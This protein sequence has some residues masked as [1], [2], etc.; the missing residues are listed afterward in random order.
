MGFNCARNI[1]SV[2]GFCSHGAGVSQWA[3][4]L[5]TASH[6]KDINVERVP[7]FGL[8]RTSNLG[9]ALLVGQRKSLPFS[10]R[11]LLSRRLSQVSMKTATV[12]FAVEYITAD[13][14]KKRKHSPEMINH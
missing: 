5:S 7:G 13:A 6:R 2:A 10:I 12:C 14:E 4:M 3:F 9:P 11:T 1:T 8:R